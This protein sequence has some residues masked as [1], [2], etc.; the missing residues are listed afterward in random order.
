MIVVKLAPKDRYVTVESVSVP[1]HT[2]SVV[3]SASLKTSIRCTA[4]SAITL[5]R[6]EKYATTVSAIHPV[7]PDKACATV[8]ASTQKIHSI[9]AVAAGLSA[10]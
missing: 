7:L 8:A 3:V 9:T 4:A 6:V 5:V 2:P 10:A 1:V